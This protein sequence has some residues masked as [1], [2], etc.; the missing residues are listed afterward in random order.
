MG[1]LNHELFTE[2]ANLYA[3]FRPT[4]PVEILQWISECCREYKVLWDCATGSGQVAIAM[5][6]KFDKIFATDLNASQLANAPPH[7]KIEYLQLPA[8]KT[9]FAENSVDLIT[10]AQALHWFEHDKFNIEVQRVLKPGGIYTQYP[11]KRM[12]LSCAKFF[13][14]K[15][16]SVGRYLHS[17]FIKFKVLRILL[18]S[19]Y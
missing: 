2:Q 6:E 9:E 1:K 8:E 11:S 17:S 19:T 5:V 15:F 3:Q 13:R 14:F 4:Y 12:V 18:C 16:Y 10:V 7:P